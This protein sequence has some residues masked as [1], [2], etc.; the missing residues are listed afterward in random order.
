MPEKLATSIKWLPHSHRF[1]IWKESRVL[2]Q[3]DKANYDAEKD[4]IIRPIE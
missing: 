1:D 4:A 2:I 3:Q